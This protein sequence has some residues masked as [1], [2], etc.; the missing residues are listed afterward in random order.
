MLQ[1]ARYLV[2]YLDT[3]V[4]HLPSLRS[5]RPPPS[6][7]PCSLSPG[8]PPGSV[9]PV[10]LLAWASRTT[11]RHIVLLAPDQYFVLWG[12]SLLGLSSFPKRT[13]PSL[14]PALHPTYTDFP[15]LTH[16]AAGTWGLPGGALTRERYPQIPQS[17][18]GTTGGRTGLPH[19]W[20]L[21]APMHRRCLYS[22]LPQA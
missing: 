4:L 9:I 8:R 5:A 13:H 17:P 15:L 19:Q 11:R 6:A 12:G 18:S 16:G 3:M 10:L 2:S 7:R 22:T 14:W 1:G 21:S 20:S